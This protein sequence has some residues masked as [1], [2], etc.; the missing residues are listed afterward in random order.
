M[1]HGDIGYRQ[2]MHELL[3]PLYYALDYDAIES[4]TCL[5]PELSEFCSRTWVATD[6]WALFG[7]IMQGVGSWYEWREPLPPVLPSPLRS[8]FRHGAPEG[9]V[10][11]QP[12]VAPIVLACQRL[13]SEMLKASDPML[14]QGLQKSGIEPQIYGM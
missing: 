9:Q 11:L 14:W 5:D 10:D 3:A 12:Y 1:V 13:Q 4:D 8:Q 2:G 6:A 7:I